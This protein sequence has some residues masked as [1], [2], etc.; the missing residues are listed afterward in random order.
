MAIVI[1][2]DAAISELLRGRAGPVVRH[3]D[4]IGTRAATLARATAPRDTGRL[5]ASVDHD[6]SPGGATVTLAVSA[7][8][9]YA[10]WQELGTGVYAGRGPIRPRRAKAL[11]FTPKGSAAVVF[12]KSVK[13]T[14]RT[15]FLFNACSAAFPY[16]ITRLLG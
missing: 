6:V 1:L 11:R 16:P 12:A 8:T 9:R 5:A 3:L 4:D 14:P 2:N 15:D 10:L 13:G 7:D